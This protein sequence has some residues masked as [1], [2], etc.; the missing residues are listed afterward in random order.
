MTP[1]KLV[2][3]MRQSN[4][5]QSLSLEKIGHGRPVK[6]C[7]LLHHLKDLNTLPLDRVT[8]LVSNYRDKGYIHQLATYLRKWEATCA[9]TKLDFENAVARC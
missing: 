2:S 6:L 9:W 8:A 4:L 7:R 3:K 5:L 1:K